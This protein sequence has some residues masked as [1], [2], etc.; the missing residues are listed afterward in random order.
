MA[1]LTETASWEPSIYRIETT[2]P[3]IGGEDGISNV[4]AKLLGNRTLYLKQVADDHEER[5]GDLETATGS[6]A[7]II[8]AGSFVKH[9]IVTAPLTNNVFDFVTVAKITTSPIVNRVTLAA[10][11]VSPIIL[12]FSKGYDANGPILY[13]ARITSNQVINL[14]NNSDALIYAEY[15]ESTGAVTFGATNATTSHVI[16]YSDPGTSGYW[17]SLKDEKLYLWNGSTW[18]VVV[19]VVIGKANW[20]GSGSF[21]MYQP[22]GK[23]IKDIYGRGQVPS[24][25]VNAFAGATAPDGYLLCNGGEISRAIYS[26]LFSAIGTIYGVGNG[27]TT[28]NLPDMRGEFIR[29]LD[30]GRGIDND[31]FTFQAT[32]T[33]GSANV[34][35]ADT[36]GLVAG[37]SITGTEIPVGATILSITNATTFVLS[38]NATATANLVSLT[39]SLTRTLGSFQNDQFQLHTHKYARLSNAVNSGSP[40]TAA[41]SDWE[42]VGNVQSTDNPQPVGGSETR[43]RNIAMNYIIKF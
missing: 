9:G 17:Y 39:V 41:I 14:G 40:T 30:G 1:N 5:V 4:Q 34:T 24:G 3:V 42:G 12:T 18:D 28:F 16:S 43:P 37:M 13:Y 11:G 20:S 33:N 6:L 21:T 27:T 8:G 26:D 15:N 7:R 10:S 29:G 32:T 19:Q 35:N 2:D 22:V 25:T 38:A 36:T 23:S 31:S